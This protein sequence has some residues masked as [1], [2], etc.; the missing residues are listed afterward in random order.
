[1]CQRPIICA[2]NTHSH[3]HT[4]AHTHICILISVCFLCI[5][6]ICF[7][8]LLLFLFSLTRHIMATGK[9]YI[10]SEA[11]NKIQHTA[12]SHSKLINCKTFYF[13]FPA[14]LLLQVSYIGQCLSFRCFYGFIS[15]QKSQEFHQI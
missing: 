6:L 2:P 7:Q 12:I 5:S 15:Y 9:L 14:Q 3:T 1:M 13:S 11:I 4:H 10:H 8:G